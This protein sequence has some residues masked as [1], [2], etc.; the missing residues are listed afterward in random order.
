LGDY[1]IETYGQIHRLAKLGTNVW[2]DATPAA[3]QELTRMGFPKGA[4]G[5]H[6]V[7]KGGRDRTGDGNPSH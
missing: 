3:E 2:T 5:Q 7:V 4:S 6:V 1:F